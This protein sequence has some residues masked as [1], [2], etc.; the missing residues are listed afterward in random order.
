M[1]RNLHIA[2]PHRQVDAEKDD[3]RKREVERRAG[4]DHD[5][6]LPEWMRIEAPRACVHAAVHPGELDETAQRNRAHRVER[7][8]SLPTEQLWPE[9]DAELLDF[10]AGE[11]GGQEMTG[12]VDDHEPAEDQDDERNEQDRAHA[13]SLL[14]SRLAPSTEVRTWRR[15]QR[16]AATTASSVK[17]SPGGAASTARR[18]DGTISSKRRCP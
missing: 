15:A 8:P 5:E 11:F 13:G 17:A 9:A 18:T 10:D 14:R 1:D 2:L 4:H 16:S 6:A 12:L 7:L 3:D